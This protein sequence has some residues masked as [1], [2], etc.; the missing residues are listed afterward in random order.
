MFQSGLLR[1]ILD[2]NDLDPNDLEHSESENVEQNILPQLR[3]YAQEN[4]ILQQ[5]NL[6][7]MVAL[8]QCENKIRFHEDKIFKLENE[9]EKLSLQVQLI[10]ETFEKSYR[11]N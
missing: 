3:E 5:K 6:E 4:K 7:L 11:K 9:N 2:P 1:N 8:N 10:I